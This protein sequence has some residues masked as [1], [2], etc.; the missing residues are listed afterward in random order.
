MNVDVLVAIRASLANSTVEHRIGH[1]FN[2]KNL[3]LSYAK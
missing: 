1:N 2:K 3:G